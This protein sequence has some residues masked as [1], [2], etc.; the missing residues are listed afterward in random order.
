MVQNKFRSNWK[1]LFIYDHER[2]LSDFPFIIE[3]KNFFSNFTRLNVPRF[4]YLDTKEPKLLDQ[5]KDVTKF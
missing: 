3:F 5:L 2:Q 1:I 4:P